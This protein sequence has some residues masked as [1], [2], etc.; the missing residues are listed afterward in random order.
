MTYLL[1]SCRFVTVPF[2]IKRRLGR[3]TPGSRQH[4]WPSSTGEWVT[5]WGELVLNLNFISVSMLWLY[6]KI[7]RKRAV[8]LD[9]NTWFLVLLCTENFSCNFHIDIEKNIVTTWQLLTLSQSLLAL[10]HNAG[11]HPVVPSAMWEWERLSKFWTFGIFNH[12]TP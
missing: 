4:K 10:G 5:N 6:K 2:P 11:W 12:Y 9:R 8:W 3:S 1:K 7:W